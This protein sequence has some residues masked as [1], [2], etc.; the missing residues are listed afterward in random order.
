M[1][2]TTV[3]LDTSDEVLLR[4]ALAWERAGKITEA[5]NTLEQALQVNPKS[6]V[7][8]LRRGFLR[9]R[10]NQLTGAL[11]DWEQAIEAQ[12][13]LT[14]LFERPEWRGPIDFAI[15]QFVYRTTNEPQSA[16]LQQFL[17][18]ACR[19][20]GRYELALQA[21][22][23]ALELQPH[24]NETE[25]I[26][27]DVFLRLG[28]SEYAA[29]TLQKQLETSPNS[30]VLHHQLGLVLYRVNSTAPAIRHLEQAIELGPSHAPSL[31]LLGEILAAQGRHE[32]AYERF[33]AGLRLNRES[34]GA[35][36]GLARCCRAMFRFEEA[37]Q[38]SR[39]AADLEPDDP[40]L[41]AELGSLHL[42]VG[43]LEEGLKALSESLARDNSQVEVHLD[44]ARAL[45]Q[46]AEP[47][48]AAEH[49][50]Q[51][52][53][54]NPK[55]DLTAFNLGC[56]QRGLG[57]L[58]EACQS[59]RVALGIKPGELQYILNLTQVQLELGQSQEAL[60]ALQAAQAQ[61]PNHAELT[62]LAGRAR[63]E[64]GLFSEAAK[65]LN[66]ALAANPEM[67]EGHALLALA[68]LALDN[69]EEAEVA[70]KRALELDAEHPL[71]ALASGRLQALRG[72]GEEAVAT[73]L[74]AL[75]ADPAARGPIVELA[76][77]A[78][79]S[80]LRAAVVEGVEKALA[81]L[82]TDWRIPGPFLRLWLEALG[83]IPDYELGGQL[84]DL[85]F[86]H[87]PEHDNV[88]WLQARW[89]LGWAR[90]LKDAGDVAGARGSVNRLL[91]SQPEHG[92][93]LVLLAT[94]E[95]PRQLASP[96][97][98]PVSP[99]RA[100]GELGAPL[101]SPHGG[102]T[103]AE[104]PP[105]E[106]PVVKEPPL[107]K[108][109]KLTLSRRE[110][111]RGPSVAK[112]R[113]VAER[114]Q[115]LDLPGGGER[116]LAQ[117]YGELAARL[118]QMGRWR[119]AAVVILRECLT[120]DPENERWEGQWSE[121]MRVA[122]DQLIEQKNKEHVAQVI[123]LW[124]ELYPDHP[125]ATEYRQA[126]QPAEAPEPAPAPTPPKAAAAP[127]RKVEA[128]GESLQD[129]RQRVQASPADETNHQALYALLKDDP[130]SLVRFYKELA[131]E[132]PNQPLH[133]LN[134]ARAYVHTGSDSLA[135][136]QY[137]RFLKAKP[138][139]EAYGELAQAY[140]RLGKSELAATTLKKAKG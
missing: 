7:V 28:Y 128:S 138:T 63:L 94:L 131:T 14:G 115:E 114:L 95:P 46:K 9:V 68:Y 57:K 67:P 78:Q 108:T 81:E 62:M 40:K 31:V 85:V 41:L 20:F 134:L 26:L 122:V 88:R 130:A 118:Q 38:Y 127:S 42:Q 34:T 86:A 44:L 33:V 16:P 89:H 54:L 79:A 21:L 6:G 4:K 27:Q 61:H 71:A 60:A 129:L 8:R 123:G 109:P 5:L 47:E 65:V 18:K 106:E 19:L 29:Q 91:Q 76:Q 15:Q 92:D 36:M 64:C 126:L 13:G 51:A 72:R 49:Y 1:A 77:A 103:P 11:D 99:P 90:R 17:G 132:F 52:L 93:A 3:G 56:V 83:K 111:N 119:D 125:E 23:T 97:G 96:L 113:R 110:P 37:L 75:R 101:P 105:V 30:A 135:V 104:P 70:V 39:R 80:E 43:H 48:K 69:P 58:S 139:P 100:S 98:A 45:Q 84:L 22:V 55:D 66:A 12:P 35:L 59:F 50:T 74:K 107:P 117:H 10:Q 112:L 133:V 32:Q 24:D 120:R 137:R 136:H 25:G 102:E 73:W 116:E 87:R 82:A 124:L 2:E 140:Q 121:L 53:R